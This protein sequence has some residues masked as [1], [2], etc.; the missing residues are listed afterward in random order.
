MITV[1]IYHHNERGADT[2]LKSYESEI[3]PQVGDVY[4]GID[5]EDGNQR[6]VIDRLLATDSRDSIIITV[7]FMFPDLAIK[8]EKD[9]EMEAA[10]KN[11]ESLS[12]ISL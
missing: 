4:A 11:E 7:D 12:E 2:R 8:K 5:F 6:K 9:K 3:I 1:V 10:K